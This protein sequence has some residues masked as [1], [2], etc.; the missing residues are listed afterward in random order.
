ME[1]LAQRLP[2][3]PRHVIWEITAACNLRCVHCE[4]NSGAR[5]PDELTAEE[6]LGLCDD[7]AAAGAKLCNVT[8][9]EPLLR[10]D[11]EAIC[12]RLAGH[13][14]DVTLVTNG[15]LLDD[16]AIRR[17]RAAGVRR[18]ALSLDGR[19]ETHDRIRPAPA[20]RG[21]NFDR[22]MTA[23]DRLRAA[24]LEAAAITHFNRW[25]LD[26]A[27]AIHG[28]L[29]GKGV[30]AWQVQLGLPLGRLREIGEPYM[31]SVEQ[32]GGLARRI[33]ALIREG[34]PPLVRV[35]DTIGYYTELEPILRRP[36]GGGLG[37]WTGC[38]AGILNVALEANGDVKGC[39]SLPAEFVSGNVRQ[40][41]FR[42]IWADESRF[43]YNT[44]WREEKLTGEC[45]RCP[46]RRLCRAGC[47]S[48]AYAVTGTIWE[49]PY[50]LHRLES[51]AMGGPV[52]P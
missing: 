52:E 41:P 22:V 21:S 4:G 44:R 50:C 26:E 30:R 29:R 7:L 19:R 43:A 2:R 39:S 8:G 10:R 33:A 28:L 46:Y 37:F 9:G 45:A 32:L 25:N 1:P 47:T 40:R 49:N 17:A 6:A 15:T 3:V 51:A 13:G 23:L 16:D 5:R 11:W 24:E 35:T 48:L 38:Y 36:A 27:E 20:V 14:I 18:V 42:E 34:L 12:A 31:I